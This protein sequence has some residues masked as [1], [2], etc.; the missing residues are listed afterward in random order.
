MLALPAAWAFADT[1]KDNL[2]SNNASVSLGTIQPGGTGSGSVPLTVD[3]TGNKHGAPGTVP[4]SVA[5]AL[6][7]ASAGSIDEVS[8]SP[9][10]TL[11]GTWPTDGSG[12]GNASKGTAVQNG[13]PG[14]ADRSRSAASSRV[15][16]LARTITM[17]GWF[18]VKKKRTLTRNDLSRMRT[19]R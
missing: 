9:S 17:L 15:T 5:K 4:F 11:P 2:D 8:V 14:E 18:R 12:C 1:L 16:V 7:S 19:A 6:A 10:V 13:R 3:C